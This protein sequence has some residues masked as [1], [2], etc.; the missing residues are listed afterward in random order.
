M[1]FQYIQNVEDTVTKC[2]IIVS[3]NYCTELNNLEYNV[4]RNIIGI[5]I[6]NIVYDLSY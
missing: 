4:E 3:I 5:Y 6:Y 1:F 2:P